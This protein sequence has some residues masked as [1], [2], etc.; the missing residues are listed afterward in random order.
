MVRRSLRDE[1]DP[2]G[3]IVDDH[4]LLGLLQRARAHLEGREPANGY[5]AIERPLHVLRGDRRAVLELGILAQLEGGGHVAD[6]HV[7]RQL[8]LELVAVV[9]LHPVGQRFHLVADEAVVAVPRHL[10]A[11]HVGADAVDVDIVRPALGN[12]EQRLLARLG[13]GGRPDGGSGKD[14]RSARC[15]HCFQKVATLHAGLVCW[16]STL[17]RSALRKGRA[18][19]Q[20]GPGALPK[21]F[22]G[23]AKTPK[24][25]RRDETRE[26]GA[27]GRPCI[28]FGMQ[29]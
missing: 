21:C 29:A 5:G 15:G 3:V 17:M 9:V 23:N 14:A 4:E 6:V 1:V 10:V 16:R 11:R 27:A 8:H 13:F 19:P 22:A 26:L 18:K 28:Q 2:D 24:Q 20:L 7:L 12:D 25:R